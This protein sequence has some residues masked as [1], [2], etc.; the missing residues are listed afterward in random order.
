MMGNK[1]SGAANWSVISIAIGKSNDH[2]C[3]MCNCTE[4][5]DVIPRDAF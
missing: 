2:V 5:V 1:M 3:S 4:A